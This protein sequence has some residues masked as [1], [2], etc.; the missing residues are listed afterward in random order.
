PARPPE[1]PTAGHE[2]AWAKLLSASPAVR[3]RS[4]SSIPR[5]RENPLPTPA[6]VPGYDLRPANESDIPAIH[7]LM[8]EMAE[9][10]KLT[11]I[12][13]ATHESVK[14]SF[15]GPEPAACCVV[16]TTTGYPS[17]SIAYLM[18]SHHYSGFLDRRGQYVEDEYVTPAHG[19]RGGGGWD[20]HHLAALAVQ[21][22]FGRFQSV[23]LDCNQNAS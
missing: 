19:G 2:K 17:T 9:F 22:G 8:L 16:I 21:V 14:Q 13:Q 7:A 12:F 20:L 15:F 5:N 11:D 10:E 4:I 23:V 6:S 1:R 3:R 18:W